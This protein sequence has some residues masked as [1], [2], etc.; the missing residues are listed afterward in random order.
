MPTAMYR[1]PEPFTVEARPVARIFRRPA[2][3]EALLG[4]IA[5]RAT[6]SGR[7][8]IYATAK[9]GC[10]AR[11]ADAARDASRLTRSSMGSAP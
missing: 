9:G 5:A 11:R 4:L 8:L 1:D 7:V 3:L 10:G 2:K 6:Q